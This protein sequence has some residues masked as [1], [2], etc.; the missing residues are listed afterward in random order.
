MLEGQLCDG[1]H[2]SIGAAAEQRRLCRNQRQRFENVGDES[3]RAGPLGRWS[4]HDEV[5]VDAAGL[6]AGI[7][8]LVEQVGRVLGAMQKSD[9]AAGDGSPG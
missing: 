7:F 4:V 2:H 9:A 8:L 1:R 3:D 6:P 5:N